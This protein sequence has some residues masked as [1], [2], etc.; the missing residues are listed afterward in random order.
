MRLKIG[1][2]VG[3]QHCHA[4]WRHGDTEALIMMPDDEDLVLFLCS[5]SSY[6]TGRLSGT[7]GLEPTNTLKP[8]FNKFN[9]IGR[10]GITY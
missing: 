6:F 4:Y 3:V 1:V 8:L 2:S 10:P 7:H 5:T 9:G